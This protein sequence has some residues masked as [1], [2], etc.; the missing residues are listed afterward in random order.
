MIKKK[1]E[2]SC[3]L[4]MILLTSTLDA[5]IETILKKISSQITE[6]EAT[7]K[8]I[9]NINNFLNEI[10]KKEQ[11]Q[12]A[13]AAEKLAGLFD[14]KKNKL[15][16]QGLGKIKE[17][18]KLS[19]HD[20]INNFTKTFKE[21]FK[22]NKEKAIDELKSIVFALDGSDDETLAEVKKKL[23]KLIL[24]LNSAKNLKNQEE[25][26]DNIINKFNTLIQ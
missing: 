22:E 23:E 15:L 2:K 24:N 13:M 4:F 25:I 7:E 16:Q 14:K 21:N 11:E 17:L 8:K 1:I 6:I 20:K 26:I 19:D 18:Q 10:P 3:A 12:R 5:E 9:E